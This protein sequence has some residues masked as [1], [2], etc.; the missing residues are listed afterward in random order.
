VS[1]A[2][3]GMDGVQST[4]VGKDFIPKLLRLRSATGDL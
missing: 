3:A 4:L 1:E 2:I